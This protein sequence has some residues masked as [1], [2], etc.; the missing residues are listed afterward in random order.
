M[1]PDSLEAEI[2]AVYV[3]SFTYALGER[4][5]HVTESAQA[6]RLVSAP[7]DLEG[8]GFGWHHLCEPGTNAYDLARSATE[9]L[10]ERDGL[11]QIDAIIYSTCLPGNG[12]VGDE[13]E[14]RRTR[15]VKY[16]MDFPASRLQAEFD[17]GEAV[18]IGLNQQAC[19]AM[20]GSLRLAGAMLAT[21]PQWRRILCVTADR[22]PEGAIYEQ[23]YNLIS[24]GAAACVVGRE[25]AGL[26]LLAS[27][28]IT[29]GALGQAS[30]DETVGTYFSFTHRLVRET[31]AKVGMTGADLDWVVS[32]NTNDKAWLILARLLGVDPARV[33]APSMRDVG[34]VISA[35]NVVNLAALLESGKL[36]P[37]HRIAL[38]MAGFGLNWQCVILEATE[39]VR[40]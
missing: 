17:L 2:D 22:F 25:P 32:Q 28:Q 18:V 21:E 19:T 1:P 9:T 6:G 34:H 30:D 11:E 16:V 33:W 38:V 15:D 40:P 12:N 39:A 7:A 3:S 4:K 26:R 37:G 20:L 10:R 8:A 24:D 14:W 29:N 36:E 5:A 27:H 13:Q 31:L 35:D 23:A